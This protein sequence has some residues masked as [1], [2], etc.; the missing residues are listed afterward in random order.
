MHFRKDFE[1]FVSP[2]LTVMMLRLNGFRKLTDENGSPA[3]DQI[4]SSVGKTLTDCYVGSCAYHYSLDE[5]IVMGKHVPEREFADACE[6]SEKILSGT[7]IDFSAV[8]VYGDA[9]D[10]QDV[11]SM[12]A[13]AE[14]MLWDRRKEGEGRFRGKKF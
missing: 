13:E 14:K 4:L 1:S 8:Y 3:G 5:F 11:R 12:I 2:E 6:R 10:S 9:K 7:G